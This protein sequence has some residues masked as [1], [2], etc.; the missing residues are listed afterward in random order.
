MKEGRKLPDSVFQV[1][2]KDPAEAE[3]WR[4]DGQQPCG[5]SSTE[6]MAD[7]ESF[8]PSVA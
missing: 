7:K 8:A 2:Q 4:T 6:R 1:Q 3:C 5:I